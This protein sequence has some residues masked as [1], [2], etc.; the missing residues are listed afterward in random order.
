MRHGINDTVAAQCM[1]TKP[2]HI[3]L[4]PG[5]IDDDQLRSSENAWAV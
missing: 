1:T 4:G 3:R 2:V 5:F